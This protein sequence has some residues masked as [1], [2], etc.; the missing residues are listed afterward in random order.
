MATAKPAHGHCAPGFH[1]V[2]AAFE[3]NMEDGDTGVAFALYQGGAIKVD[4]R[5]QVR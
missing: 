2:G 1:A 3:R 4:A 5:W